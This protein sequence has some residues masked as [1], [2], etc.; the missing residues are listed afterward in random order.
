MH[1]ESNYRTEYAAAA[2]KASAIYDAME[3][4][5]ADLT[6]LGLQLDEATATMRRIQADALDAGITYAELVA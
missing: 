2:D 3:R 1:M 5:G 6:A 4:R